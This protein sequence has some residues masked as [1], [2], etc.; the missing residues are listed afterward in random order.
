[1]YLHSCSL[2]MSHTNVRSQNLAGCLERFI[3][4]DDGREVRKVCEVNLK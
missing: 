4:W 1:M 3:F 2:P